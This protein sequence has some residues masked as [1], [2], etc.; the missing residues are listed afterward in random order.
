MGALVWATMQ[1]RWATLVGFAGLV[2]GAGFQQIWLMILGGAL[3]L[4]DLVVR[5]RRGYQEAKARQDVG[6]RRPPPGSPRSR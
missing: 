6:V 5:S 3:F 4:G 2:L 1:R